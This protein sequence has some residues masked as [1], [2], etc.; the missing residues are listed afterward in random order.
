L[1][2]MGLLQNI[3][4]ESRLVE[5]WR[6]PKKCRSIRG[7][8]RSG[9]LRLEDVCSG[10]VDQVQIGKAVLV[11]VDPGAPRAHR[12]DHELLRR[13]GV[14]VAEMDPGLPGDVG[15]AG[16]ASASKTRIICTASTTSVPRV[17]MS[18]SSPSSHCSVRFRN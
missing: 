2:C 15:E 1:T 12:L 14:L 9:F 4:R 18:N 8:R 17:L 16:W 3:I 13:S 7:S 10:A 6:S 5:L 11:V